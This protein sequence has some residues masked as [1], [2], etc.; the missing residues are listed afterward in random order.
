M[1]EISSSEIKS[2]YTIYKITLSDGY[3]YVGSTKNFHQRITNHLSDC[4]NSKI[5]SYN[6]PLYKHIRENNLNFDRTCFTVLEQVE[7]YTKREAEKIEEKYRKEFEVLVGGNILNGMRAYLT[8]EEKKEREKEWYE[9]N[10]VKK[11]DYNTKYYQNNKEERAE[12]NRVYYQNNKEKIAERD[13]ERNK[14]PWHCIICN[15]TITK[16]CKARHCRSQTHLNNLS[17]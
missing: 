8:P 9:K 15:V 2:D 13:K 7:N 16:G 3:C 10:K 17:K 1:S 14:Q 12:Y 5:N 4:Y 11:A 6:I